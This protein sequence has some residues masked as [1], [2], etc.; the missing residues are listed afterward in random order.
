MMHNYKEKKGTNPSQVV[1][2]LQAPVSRIKVSFD[3]QRFSS[4]IYNWSL[5]SKNLK[6]KLMKYFNF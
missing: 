4:A 5:F 1:P 2:L 6:K 3:V